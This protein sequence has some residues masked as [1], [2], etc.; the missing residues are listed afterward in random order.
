[1]SHT[2]WKGIATKA[3]TKNLSFLGVR[4][5]DTHDT[6]TVVSE[7]HFTSPFSPSCDE[8]TFVARDSAIGMKIF[9]EDVTLLSEII[10]GAGS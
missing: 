8:Q 10:V 1:M 2:V 9:S 4:V 6:S 7:V 3:C 5:H